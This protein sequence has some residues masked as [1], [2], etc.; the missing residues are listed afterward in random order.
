MIYAPAAM[1]HYSQFHTFPFVL[2]VMC[3][4]YSQTGK[5]IGI[6]VGREKIKNRKP[7]D[8]PEFKDGYKSILVPVAA[9]LAIMAP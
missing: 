7:D 8:E 6:I 3:S 5:L 9:I 1:P 2:A 4:I